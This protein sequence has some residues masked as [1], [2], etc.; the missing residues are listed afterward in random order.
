MMRTARREGEGVSSETVLHTRSTKLCLHFLSI[1]RLCLKR[2]DLSKG[3][4]RVVDYDSVEI[5]PFAH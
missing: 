1:G 2:I 3:N 4:I 5:F